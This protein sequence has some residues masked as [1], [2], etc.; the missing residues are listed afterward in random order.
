MVEEVKR[1]GENLSSRTPRNDFTRVCPR[2][3]FWEGEICH[4]SNFLNRL[5]TL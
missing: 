5:R 3:E 1:K 2:V 4:E